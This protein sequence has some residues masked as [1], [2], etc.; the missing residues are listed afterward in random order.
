MVTVILLRVVML[1]V[2]LQS[3]IMLIAFGLSVIMLSVMSP[4][5]EKPQLLFHHLKKCFW[6]IQPSA[7]LIFPADNI[8]VGQVRQSYKTFYIRNLRMFVIS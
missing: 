2:I 7:P 3:V 8:P 5:I 1:G 6:K 4:F